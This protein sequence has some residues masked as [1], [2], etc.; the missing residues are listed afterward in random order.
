MPDRCGLRRL[1]SPP[2]LPEGDRGL[3][4]GPTCQTAFCLRKQGEFPFVFLFFVDL[5][6]GSYEAQYIFMHSERRCTLAFDSE[7]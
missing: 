7:I 6:G 5:R 4:P 2:V 3:R 1:R